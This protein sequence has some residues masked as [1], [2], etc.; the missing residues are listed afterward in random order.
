MTPPNH[1][2]PPAARRA[3]LLRKIGVVGLLLG[4]LCAPPIAGWLLALEPLHHDDLVPLWGFA[5]ALSAMSL[6]VGFS[7]SPHRQKVASVLVL[8]LVLVCG[9]LTFR[10]WVAFW[11]RSE[12]E[13]LIL[14]ARRTYPDTAAY[15]PH[16]F[17]QFTGRPG[18]AL[19][20]N[21]ALG[22]L[23]P[24]N[25]R[26]FLGPDLAPDKPPSAIRVACL[27]GSTTARGYPRRMQDFLRE[28]LGVALGVEVMNFGQG[29]Y[30]S[31]H[32]VVNFA[33][34]VSDYSPDYVVFHHAWNDGRA[35][36]RVAAVRGDYGH[37]LKAFDPP[38][39][40][41]AALIR[42]STLYRWVKQELRGEPDWAFLG[43]AVVK[44]GLT[45]PGPPFAD[46]SELRPYERNVRSVVDLALAR[47]VVPVLVTQPR[48]TDPDVA[49]ALV[50][51]HIDQCNEI[52]RAVAERY[53]EAVVLV[54]LAADLTGQNE[55]F[56]DIAHMTAE[57]MDQKAEAVGEAIL[58]NLGR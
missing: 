31:A 52:V 39:I 42:G 13:A 36:N 3:R 46:V 2:T 49:V 4:L 29:W 58:A 10:A 44:E 12:Q 16:P 48:S 47:G 57:G 55:I 17:L 8:A 14:L 30:T 32:S 50:A 19:R 9:E 41:D 15:Q 54:D 51:P 35:R 45:K 28:R 40:L 24:Y 53:G 20:G 37:A 56:V 23:L 11:P 18:V 26:G 21:E 6:F 1:R 25:E 34:N 7:A 38:P 22:T 33:L 43:A 5:A 27:G